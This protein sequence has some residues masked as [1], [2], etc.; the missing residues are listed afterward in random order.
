MSRWT[1]VVGLLVLLGAGLLW[2][3]RPVTGADPEH[4]V[5]LTSKVEPQVS[6]PETAARDAAL[7]R[8]PRIEAGA[9]RLEGLVVDDEE[10]PLGGV[11]VTLDGARVA[12]TEADGSFA[13][14]GLAPRTYALNAE[15]GEW[16][17]EQLEATLD[18]TSDPVTIALIRGPTLRVHVISVGGAPITGAKVATSSRELVTGPSGVVVLRGIDPGV[19]HLRVSAAGHAEV[20]ERLATGDDPTST[21]ERT[22]VLVSG[23]PLTGSVVDEDGA[24][25]ANASVE[26]ET[27]NGE[28]T[29]T[30]SSDDTGAWTTMDIAAG[31]YMLRGTSD[32]HVGTA[33]LV[34]PHD[35]IT[36]KTGLVIR[37]ARGGE[38]VGIVKHAGGAPAEGVRVAVGRRRSTTGADGRFVAAGLDP[39]D[40][41][42]TAG[43]ER[44]GAASQSVKLAARGHLE[45]TF[46]LQPSSI[47]GRVVSPSGEPIEDVLVFA[48]STDPNGFGFERTDEHG[49]FDLGGLPPGQYEVEVQRD[50]QVTRI[51]ATKVNVKSGTRN[52]RIELPELAAIAGRVVRA[53]VPVPYFGI[54]VSPEGESVVTEI[55]RPVRDT[56]GT[57]TERGMTAGTW[58]VAIVGPGFERRVI[59]HVRITAGQTTELG[60]ISVTA[61]ESVR[62]R[63][64][65]EHGRAIEGA[66][67]EITAGRSSSDPDRLRA[68]IGDVYSA[69]TD[70]RGEFQIDGMSASES[71]QIEAKH[72]TLGISGSQPIEP[73]RSQIEVVI[74]ATGSIGGTLVG[75]APAFRIY[76]VAA[77]PVDGPYE[78]YSAEIDPYGNFEIANLPPGEYEVR[79]RGRVVVPRQQVTVVAGSRNEIDF[80]LP[81]AP[82]KLIVQV[83]G[84][85]SLVWLR[86]PGSSESLEH[87]GCD[88]GSATFSGVSPGRYDVCLENSD[89]REIDVPAQR[90]HTV[91]VVAQS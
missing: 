53:G 57:F 59:E 80:E 43:N 65:D 33:D 15:L 88:A 73:G 45:L 26:I 70:R 31:T 39:D 48:R 42:V 79:V 47:A 2:H 74:R 29:E 63:V 10:R 37:I 5:S 86:L 9:L 34:V 46:V 69:T 67:V 20:H 16:Y 32:V 30:V 84:E 41:D 1:I 77:T 19:D 64:V 25:V 3:A 27:P 68:L 91:R 56:K 82:V 54:A 75:L 49:A 44:E 76:N 40:Y 81:R 7:R 72:P 85:C 58:T 22:I 38:I 21:L 6:S 83:V 12:V 51:A 60:D 28:R 90:E 24:I 62:G 71:R 36:K 35:G 13:F 89:C 17:G 4:D 14:G 23:A 18:D 50:E 61:G 52:V 11:R 66:K 78:M 55:P 87:E 8:W